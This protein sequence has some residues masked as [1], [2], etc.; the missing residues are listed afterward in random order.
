MGSPGY[1]YFHF[2]SS[3]RR[4]FPKAIYQDKTLPAK[5]KL[6]SRAFMSVAPNIKE[7]DE[8][9]FKLQRRIFMSLEI[10]LK[11]ASWGEARPGGWASVRDFL[12][13]DI[14]SGCDY[15][16]DM[17]SHSRDEAGRS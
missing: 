11:P 13:Q 17:R 14:S 16:P 6:F 5:I 2:C 7:N 3:T 1:G 12:N 10:V 8:L 4:R 9:S 15:S